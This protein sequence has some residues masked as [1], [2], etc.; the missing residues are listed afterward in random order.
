MIAADSSSV[1]AYFDGK[2]GNDVTLVQ[3]ALASA[4]I[5][6]PPVVLAEI[7]SDKRS[8]AALRR[9][10]SQWPLL[11]ILPEYWERAGW[12]RANL[13]DRG[14]KPKLPDTLIAQSCIDHSVALIT[15]DSGFEHFARH[16]G[17]KLA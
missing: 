7:L 10:V 11:E 12:L 1:I 13:I 9:L 15:R 2:A 8:H 3:T 14:L 17:L 4:D 6:L 5:C 16:G